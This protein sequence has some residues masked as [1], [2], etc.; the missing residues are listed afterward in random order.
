MSDQLAV[1]KAEN[2]V[3]ALDKVTGQAQ[4]TNDLRFPG[5]LHAK[6]KRSLLGHANI[7]DIDTSRA[8]RVPGVRAIVTGKEFAERFSNPLSG[9]PLRDQPFLAFDRVRFAGEGVAV[10]AA[11]TE[12]AAEEAVELIKV[13][14]EELPALLNTQDAMREDAVVIHEDL[15]SY[16]RSPAMNPLSGTNICDRIEIIGGNIDKG[17]KE[18]DHIFENTFNTQTVQHTAMEP[19]VAI[20]RFNVDGTITVWTSDQ[21]PYGARSNL[22]GALKIPSSKVR[23]IVPPM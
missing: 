18:A 15:G 9:N 16:E 7:I 2:R 11:E 12:E 17:F 14:Y 21:A 20:A 8:E 23:I 10:V 1:G 13:E 6:V 4:Y 3:D 5:L 19:R 22:A